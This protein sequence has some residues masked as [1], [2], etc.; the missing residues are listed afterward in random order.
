[1]SLFEELKRRNVFRVVAAYLVLGWLALQISDVLVE[2][3][4]L[5]LVWSRALIGMLLIGFI[6]TVVFSWVYEMTPEGLKKESEVTRDQSI[7]SMTARKLDTAVIGLLIVAIGL[8]VLDRFTGPPE[9]VTVETPTPQPPAPVTE[10]QPAVP[11][12]AVLPLKTMSTEEE[13]T[14][15]AAG[16]HDDLLTKL[17][18]LQAY[19]VI[20]RTSVME[21]ADTTKNMRQIGEELGAG[22]IVE[23]GLQAIGGRVSINA[24]LIDTRT[25]E[26]LWAETF[27]HELTTANL[28]EIQGEIA[29]AIADAMHATLSPGEVEMLAQVP[30]QNLDAY[31]AYLRGLEHAELLTQ[32]SL[33]AAEQAFAE[34]VSLDP[35]FAGAWARLGRALIRRYWEEG[36]ESDANPDETYVERARRALD[37]AQNLAPNNV[38]VLLSEAYF[39]YYAY[40]DYSSALVELDKA[41]NIAPYDN[42][43]IALRGFLLRRLG[44]VS[45]AADQLIRAREFSPAHKGHLRETITT[46]F[47]SGR[48]EESQQLVEEALERYPDTPGIL[49]ASAASAMVCA[50]DFETA[51]VLFEK[52][53]ITTPAELQARI[54]FLM[55]SGNLHGAI[56][57][58]RGEQIKSAHGPLMQFY[59]ANHLTALYELTGQFEFAEESRIRAS[60]MAADLAPQGAFS[61]QQLAMEAALR[62]DSE[63]ALTL[64]RSALEAFPRDAY[65]KPLFEYRLLTVI[66][67]TGD[68]P[69][70]WAFFLDWLPTALFAEL[71]LSRYHPFLALLRSDPRFEDTLEKGMVRFEQ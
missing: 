68:E 7:T 70:T 37:R 16:L 52:I 10:K 42:M 15:L 62:G 22:Y 65:M 53:P 58:A 1:L 24:Q 5:P 43:V 63:K 28:F 46:L 67:L 18:K 40:R 14:F 33:V 59:L 64:A 25:D 54:E 26:H 49:L 51:A 31:R 11:V 60:D 3:L 4:E 29:T 47:D 69:E 44:Q 56:D 48:C 6:P 8:F 34:A 13:G 36:G 32:P 20:S 12:V 39:H 21:Y 55:Y 38:E 45:E 41:E 9:V 71:Q 57:L 61:L 30:T 66:A 50:S 27:N 35:E 19:K 23:G 17:A 2:A